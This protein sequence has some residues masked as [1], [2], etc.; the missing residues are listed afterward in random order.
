M[1]RVL[2]RQVCRTGV[3]TVEYDRENDQCW[4][5]IK[6]R[7]YSSEQPVTHEVAERYYL[8]MVESGARPYQPGPHGQV[9]GKSNMLNG[10]P[11]CD[12]EASGVA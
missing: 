4:L 9:L 2:V 1:R 3:Q 11:E 12:T 10:A 5:T 8:A 6:N 7:T